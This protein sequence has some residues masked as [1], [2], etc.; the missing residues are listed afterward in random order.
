M[1]RVK[2]PHSSFER[3][4][5]TLTWN[6]N[7]TDKI[8]TRLLQNKHLFRPKNSAQFDISSTDVP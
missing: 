7:Y 8:K 4:N 2:I 5:R 6:Y 1:Y 3:C